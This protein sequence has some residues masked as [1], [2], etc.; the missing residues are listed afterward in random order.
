MENRLATTGVKKRRQIVAKLKKSAK[1]GFVR[2]PHR[3]L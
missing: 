2:R 3:K 1:I